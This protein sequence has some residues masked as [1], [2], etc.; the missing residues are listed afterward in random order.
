MFLQTFESL[1]I[2]IIKICR[3]WAGIGELNYH[4]QHSTRA[5]AVPLPIQ[6]PDNDSVEDGT[7]T[8][9][10]SPLPGDPDWSSW[11]LIM[12]YEPIDE[13]SL[14]LPLSL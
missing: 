4:C 12:T 13:R 3:S 9:A 5:L 11:V 2:K 6:F 14:S 10:L 8:L 1:L 7:N